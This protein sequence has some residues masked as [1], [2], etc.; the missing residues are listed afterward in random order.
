MEGGNIAMSTVDQRIVD[1]RFNNQQFES[2]IKSSIGSLDNLKNSLKLEEAAKGLSNLNKTAKDVSLSTMA[3]GIDSIASKFNSLGIIGLTIIQRLTNAAIDFGTKMGKAFTIDPLSQG[4]DEYEIKMNSIQTFLSNTADKGTTLDDVNKSLAELNEYADKTIYNFAQMTDNAAKFT[5]AGLDLKDAVTNTKGLANIA[6]GF[7]VDATKMAGATYQM[8]QA[9]QNGVIKLQDWNSMTQAGMGGQSLQKELTKTAKS[10]GIVTYDT[11][12]FRDS[13]EKGWLTAEVFTKTMARMAEDPALLKAAT[14]VTTFTKMIGVMKESLASGW[15]TSWEKI[16]GGAEDSKNIWTSLYNAFTD[17]VTASANMRNNMLEVWAT[18]G[19]RSDLIMG[20]AN[21]FLFLGKVLGSVQD[22]FGKIFPPITSA[23]LIMLSKKFKEL[24]EWF[25][26]SDSTADKLSRTFQGVFAIFSIGKQALSAIGNSLSSMLNYLLPASDGFLSFTAYIGD[27]IVAIDSA[28]KSSDSFNKFMGKIE[29]I[30]TPI[31]NIIK[32]VTSRILGMASSISFFG[33]STTGVEGIFDKLLNFLGDVSSKIEVAV[34][35][36]FTSIA[37][38]FNNSNYQDLL[39]ILNT[40]ILATIFV[41]IRNFI[42]MIKGNIKGNMTGGF[43]EKFNS[44][45]EGVTG[46]L[47]TMQKALRANILLQIGIAIGILAVALAV[48]ASIDANKLKTALGAMTVMIMELFGAMVIFERMMGA[49]GFLAIGKITLSMIGLSIAILILSSALKRISVLDFESITKGLFGVAGLALILVGSAKLLSGVASSLISSSTGFILLSVA[50]LLLSKSLIS[51]S[52]LDMDSIGRGLLGIGAILLS[53]GLFM[54]LIK[55]NNMGIVTSVGLMALSVAV[56]ALGLAVR[57]FADM[58]QNKLIQG[59][60][61]LGVLLLEVGLFTTL[62]G[63]SKKVILTATGLVILG[64]AMIIFSSA[65]AR[66]GNLPLENLGKGL[67]AMAAA[68]LIVGVAMSVIP[69]NG[70]LIGIGLTVIAGALLLISTSLATMGQMSLN[71]VIKSLG[72]LAGSLILITVAI[73]YMDTSV[74]GLFALYM[75][76]DALSLLTPVLTTLGDMSLSQIGIA[77][78]ALAGA[79]TVLG[80]AGWLM[81]PLTPVLLALSGSLFVFSMSLLGISASMAIFAFSIATIVAAIAAGGLTIGIFITSASALV[82][83]LPLLFTNLAKGFVDGLKVLGD[84]AETIT[85]S[86]S[87][88]LQSVLDSIIQLTPYL[89]TAVADFISGFLDSLNN[90]IYKITDVVIRIF[91]KF[92]E[93]VEEGLPIITEAAITFI[94]AFLDGLAEGID[95]HEDKIVKV[96]DKLLR[97]IAKA[98]WNGAIT[99]LPSIMDLIIGGALD[100]TV[101]AGKAISKGLGKGMQAGISPAKAAANDLSG[102]VKTTITDAFEINSPSKWSFENGYNIAKSM[103]SGLEAGQ[104]YSITAAENLTADVIRT[105]SKYTLTFDDLKVPEVKPKNIFT[106]AYDSLVKNL[107]KKKDDVEK[108]IKEPFK[109]VTDGFNRVSSGVGTASKAIKT[110]FEIFMEGI[111]ERKYYNQLTLQQELDAYSSMLKKYGALTDEHKKLDREVYRVKNEIVKKGFETSQKYLDQEKYY[112]RL[113]LTQELTYW[114]I[115]QKRYLQGSEERTTA[116][117]E[118]YRVQE[119]LAKDAFQKSL[120]WIDERKFY[121]GSISEELGYWQILQ[122]RYAEDNVNHKRAD[123]ETFTLQ[124]EMTDTTKSNSDQILDIHKNMTDSKKQ[125]EEDYY[126]KTKEINDKLKDD[127]K[128]VTDEYTNALK[129]RTDTLYSTYSLFEKVEPVKIDKEK[130]KA[131][132]AELASWQRI[133]QKYLEGTAKRKLADQ[134]VARVETALSANK[135]VSG[136]ELINN[137]KSQVTEIETWKSSMTS[138]SSKINEKDLV[139]ELQDVGPKSIEQIKALNELSGPELDIY[140]ALWKRKH[141][142]AKTQ[143]V[144]ELEGLRTSSLVKIGELEKSSATE[145][146]KYVATWKTKMTTLKTETSTQIG[147]I[148][149]EWSTKIGEFRSDTENQFVEMIKT[150]QNELKKLNWSKL[151]TGLN[152]AST[153]GTKSPEEINSRDIIKKGKEVLGLLTSRVSGINLAPVITPVLDASKL[154]QGLNT[155]FSNQSL[156]VSS[157]AAKTADIATMRKSPIYL[158]QQ[159][160]TTNNT[161]NAEINITNNYTVRSDN[162]IRNISGSLNNMLQKYYYAQGVAVE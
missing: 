85:T 11:L 104:Y 46:S 9:L 65:I 41:G 71:G 145:L 30:L 74:S 103:G 123:R 18:S 8:T 142:D 128:A 31:G 106:S 19:G 78:L 53:L 72:A 152:G 114:E 60:S 112:N 107:T 7:G 63:D 17:V 105:M 119:E 64:G 20:I 36:I 99:I 125:L 126:A 143:A 39:G 147:L 120:D 88:I 115:I 133:Q 86:I 95:K 90:N 33:D 66:M 151:E 34:S 111:D 28:L 159:P 61:A 24:T 58:D 10:L 16:L 47:G 117:R 67:G 44:I 140:V 32:M 83:V 59:L 131:L 144:S 6:A 79:F 132:E 87:N 51:I 5:A 94:V 150:I 109:A 98:L 91:V 15:A 55:L 148:N 102:G 12:S 108:K 153:T 116:D 113:T 93:K 84:G 127:V 157:I 149:K 48:L 101:S 75:M 134:Q 129:S 42:N 138:L 70:I 137:L 96:V 76:A 56:L 40:G 73:N 82:G 80:V 38:G 35:K 121:G 110:A 154:E 2:G 27:F 14:N 29:A 69:K 77:L 50:L 57:K 4:F 52:A 100:G 139:K 155:T 68:L 97:S 62:T 135:T 136:Q 25:I 92:L 141:E 21:T 54:K 1:M 122:S 156:N 22:A 3:S 23:T 161:K 160:S 124:K 162:D 130:Q 49:A 26:I 158:D 81:A 45:I 146:D 89:I 13:L 43:M 37:D 118:V